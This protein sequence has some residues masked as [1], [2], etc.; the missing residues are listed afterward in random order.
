M[1]RN[2]NKFKNQPINMG[3]VVGRK[4]S[5]PPR[6]NSKARKI[7]SRSKTKKTEKSNN[8]TLKH[9]KESEQIFDQTAKTGFGAAAL[10]PTPI[11]PIERIEPDEWGIAMLQEDFKLDDTT[12]NGVGQHFQATEFI[13]GAKLA[14]NVQYQQQQQQEKKKKGEGKSNIK[15]GADFDGNFT[16]NKP[17]NEDKNTLNNQ[18]PL[19]LDMTGVEI[20]SIEED[21]KG[22]FKTGTLPP[23]AIS[24]EDQIPSRRIGRWNS[25]NSNSRKVSRSQDSLGR[26]RLQQMKDGR[27]QCPNCSRNFNASNIIIPFTSFYVGKEY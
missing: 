19:K 15:V 21:D 6:S 25:S 17:L 12:T 20:D 16:F 8:F 4:R 10:N 13:D 26:K 11:K 2:Q 1:K 7:R 23:L 22:F 5:R 18:I 9:L 24:G 3:R 14:K 27:V